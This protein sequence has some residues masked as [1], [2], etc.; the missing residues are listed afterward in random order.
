MFDGI[1]D[2]NQ[3]LLTPTEAAAILRL[4]VKTLAVW[5]CRKRYPLAY[6]KCGAKVRYRRSDVLKFLEERLVMGRVSPRSKR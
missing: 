5:R 1:L 6:I 3:D 2:P 4:S